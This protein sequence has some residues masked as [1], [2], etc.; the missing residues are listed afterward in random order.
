[1]SEKTYISVI[2]PLPLKWFPCYS[3]PEDA[4]GRIV[5]GSRVTV[6]FASRA[7]VA[8]VRAVGVVPDVDSS[9]VR[10]VEAVEDLAPVSGQELELWQFISDYYLCSVGEVYLAAYPSFNL[11]RERAVLAGKLREE[12]RRRKR[13]AELEDRLRRTEGRISRKK[14]QLSLL[15]PSSKVYGRDKEL[16]ERQLSALNGSAL[17]IRAELDSLKPSGTATGTSMMADSGTAGFPEKAAEGLP[18]LSPAQEKAAAEIREAFSGNRIALLDGVTGSGKTEI[19]A[20]LASEVLGKGKSVLYLVPE[21]AMSFQLEC[22]LRK[23]FGQSLLVCSSSVPDSERYGVASS[24]RMGPHVV[25]GTR[26]A[27][28]LPFGSLGLVVVDEEHDTSL[29]QD[30]MAPRY[31][32]RDC[33]VKLGSIHGCP[34]LLGSATPSFESL[35]NC[36]AGRYAHVRLGTRFFGDDESRLELIDT[37]AER[38][39]RGMV[40]SISRKLISHIRAALDSGG[41]VLVLRGRRS[42]SPLVQCGDCGRIPRCP[43]CNV[44]L[45]YHKDRD[46]LL[47][48][49]CGFRE[50]FAVRCP[51]CGGDRIF[52][53]SGTQKVEEEIAALFPKARVARLDGDSL[54]S[55]QS[56]LRDFAEGGIDILVGTQMVSKGLDFGNVSL[57]AV[58]QSDTLLGMEDFRADERA[59]QLLRQLRGRGGRRG[60]PSLFVIQTSQPSH[61]VY[62]RLGDA[63]LFVNDE[64]LVRKAF[65]YPPF[66]RLVCVTVRG[67]DSRAVEADARAAAAEFAAALGAGSPAPGPVGS[68]AAAVSGPCPPPVDKVAGE[69]LRQIRIS[70]PRDASL[71]KRKNLIRDVAERLESKRGFASRIIIDVDPI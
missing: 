30:S 21:I 11:K 57:V 71:G 35:Y 15:K 47:C 8:V 26:S 66:V 68:A 42:Y 19:Y 40:G 27:I 22:R 2:L 33:A 6:R 4:V 14:E 46:A 67:K 17:G 70:L 38:R 58:V 28:F 56:V 55:A 43:H 54:S 32:G 52:I 53:G 48:H 62:G 5:R 18:L 13:I 61:P 49:Y 34:V 7:Y 59:F 9:K 29:K 65:S 50:G 63:D 31:N 3:V 44:P 20:T 69:Y 51:D 45:C 36:Y 16:Y 23:Y 1:M 24:L 39:K 25:L 37:A 12:E 60:R 10:P 64:L 41:Q